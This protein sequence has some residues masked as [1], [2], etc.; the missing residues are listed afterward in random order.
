MAISVPITSTWEPKGLNK[1]ISDIKRAEGGWQKAGV[2][3][4]KAFLPA[5]AALGGLAAGGLAAAKSAEATATANANLAQSFKSMGYPEQAAAAKKYAEEL[6]TQIGI[7]DEIIKNSQAKLATFSQIAR[8]ADTMGRSTT[9]AADLAAKGFGSMDSAAVLLGKALEN[10]TKGVSA[11]AR[12]GVELT[13]SQK[14]QVKALQETGDMAGAQE[15]IFGA[16]E[17]QVGGTAKATANDTD[18]MAVAWSNVTSSIGTLLLPVLAK[19]T[20]WTLKVTK[21]LEKNSRAVVIAAGV[22]GALAAAIVTVNIIMKVWRT[23]TLVFTAV[24]WALNAALTANPIG[25]VVAAIAL[26]VAGLVLAYKKSETFRR[27]VD[28]VFGFVKRVV[29]GYINAWVSAL[30]KVWGWLQRVIDVAVRVKNAIKDAFSI[31]VPGFISGLFGGNSTV[32]V[33][34]MTPGAS[35]LTQGSTRAAPRTVNVTL[36]GGDPYLVA[37]QLKRSLEGYDLTQG[38]GRGAPLAVSW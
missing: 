8:S 13:D 7:D 28:A 31:K 23:A 21:Y 38:R 19:L 36:N 20:E 6:S 24:Q 17:K 2:V 26:L 33:A 29:V 25:L 32:S 9:L 5:V 27:I 12:V 16:L 35:A 10:P 1:S 34:G 14:E 15:V 22:I 37:R 11:L 3:A 4:Q 18:K 30:T